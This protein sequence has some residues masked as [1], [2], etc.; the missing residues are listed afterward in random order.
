MPT[1]F[2]IIA[3]HP[4]LDFVNTL[5]DRFADSGPNELLRGYADLLSFAQQAG[6]LEA[7]QIKALAAQKD[8]TA[9]TAALR[10]AHE[11]REALAAF[12]YAAE[13]PR[14]A[15]DLRRSRQVRASPRELK[16]ELKTMERHF[17]QADAHRELTW[18]R[19]PKLSGE[20]PR[21]AWQ[22][23]RYASDVELPVWV[24]A[25]SAEQLLTSNAMEHVR[26]CG[27]DTCR[28]LFYDASKNHSRRWCDMKICGNRMKARRFQARHD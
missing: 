20:I 21:A 22:W 25:R 7:P 1:A 16:T 19:A 10:S 5:D 11:L 2:Q 23:G 12:F 6:I 13:V 26:V 17:L 24:L 4:A 9:A 3:G 15:G 18:T 8:A 14:H 28:W 27:S